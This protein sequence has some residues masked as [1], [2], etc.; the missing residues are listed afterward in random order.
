MLQKLEAM[1]L[2]SMRTSLGGSFALWK[3]QTLSQRQEIEAL[4]DKENSNAVRTAAPWPTI[5]PLDFLSLLYT[6]CLQ[7][8]AVRIVFS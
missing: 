1:A 2:H 7:P 3:R 5:Q 8:L 4:R 6:L